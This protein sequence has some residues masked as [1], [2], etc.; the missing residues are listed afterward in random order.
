V[1]QQSILRFESQTYQ[2]D[3]RS[4]VLAAGRR[5]NKK[6]LV[7]LDIKTRVR[8]AALVIDG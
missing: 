6:R 2:Y 1:T 5:Y 7:A 8:C 3:G 4:A